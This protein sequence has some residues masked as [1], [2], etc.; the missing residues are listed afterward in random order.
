MADR[1]FPTPF[2]ESV[3][4]SLCFVAADIFGNFWNGPFSRVQWNCP[5]VL[6]PFLELTD[7]ERARAL[8][9]KL[10]VPRW[11]VPAMVSTT[12]VTALNV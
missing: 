9:T 4:V 2:Y 6:F 10:A 5:P 8:T 3:S 12:I 7:A 1:H 11:I